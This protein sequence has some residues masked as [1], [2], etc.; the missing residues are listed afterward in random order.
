MK[1][2]ITN[3]PLVNE[4]DIK[5]INYLEGKDYLD[6]LI[7]V[8]D[9]IH[10]NHKLLTHPLA[11]NFLPDKTIYKTIIVEKSNE[12]DF[13]GV[14]LISDAIT[15]SESALTRRNQKI[16]REDILKDLQY[17]DYQVIKHSLS[18]VKNTY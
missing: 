5:N 4:E 14:N 18:I 3:N 12:L 13:E 10:N 6:V 16:F 1:L 11:S 17:V 2:V 8:R 9:L 15:L 7:T